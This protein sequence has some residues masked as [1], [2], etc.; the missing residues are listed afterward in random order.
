MTCRQKGEACVNQTSSDRK[1]K[2]SRQWGFPRRISDLG[3]CDTN[4]QLHFS[5]SRTFLSSISDQTHV[6]PVPSPF[7]PSPSRE[8]ERAPSISC[9][10]EC[11]VPTDRSNDRA[12]I[13]ARRMSPALPRSL[14]PQ[15]LTRTDWQNQT[16]RMWVQ[17][18]AIYEEG[19]ESSSQ[20]HHGDLTR[21]IP[22]NANRISIASLLN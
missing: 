17:K 15:K 8:I 3:S 18:T 21:T 5:A 20:R 12:A 22:P 2:Q 19:S 4:P 1:L 9:L 10:P 11:G 13:M 7:Q 14:S 16:V 6:T